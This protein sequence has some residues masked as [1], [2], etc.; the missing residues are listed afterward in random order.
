MGKMHWRLNSFSGGSHEGPGK[1]SRLLSAWT[2]FYQRWIFIEFDGQYPCECRPH[3]THFPGVIV[4]GPTNSD[5][6]ALFVPQS[7]PGG[8]PSFIKFHW[9]AQAWP[10][11]RTLRWCE[12][13]PRLVRAWKSVANWAGTMDIGFADE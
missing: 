6:P 4:K 7:P 12:T 5:L 1:L 8:A 9:G 2:L 13:G 11:C 3:C 10:K